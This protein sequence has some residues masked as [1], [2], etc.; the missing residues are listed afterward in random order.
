METSPGQRV[1]HGQEIPSPES[2]TPKKGY[3]TLK[4]ALDP[5]LEQLTL[6]LAVLH[7]LHLVRGTLTT[8]VGFF[9]AKEKRISLEVA[10]V[11]VAANVPQ[12]GLLV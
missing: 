2:G 9:H 6:H 1:Q 7:F 11:M 5:Q 4:P 8:K 3:T 12:T 10:M